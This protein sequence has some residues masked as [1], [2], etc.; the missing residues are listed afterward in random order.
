MTRL[1]ETLRG[2]TSRTRAAAD[3]SYA[4][5]PIT[6]ADIPGRW[7]SYVPAFR[8]YSEMGISQVAFQRYAVRRGD[9]GAGAEVHVQSMLSPFE[10][11]LLY[12]LAKDYYTGRGAIVDLGPYFGLSTRAL[13][14]GLRSNLRVP[15][16]EKRKRIHSFDLFLTAGYEWF[17]DPSTSLP[18]G[19]IFDF[20]LELNREYLDFISYNPGDLLQLDWTPQEIEILFIDIAKSWEL[21]GFVV[22]KMF[23]C[24]IPG[25]SIVIQQ[26]YVHFH[27]YWIHLTMQYLAEHFELVD[28]MYGATV[29]FLLKDAIPPARLATDLRSLSVEQKSDLLVAAREAAPDPIRESMKTAHAMMLADHGLFDAALALLHTVRAEKTTE[30]RTVDFAEVTQGNV[31]TVREVIRSRA[32]A[33][34]SS[35]VR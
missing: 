12:A 25:R 32:A 22:R 26:D 27:E 23:P 33:T 21:N 19:S 18:S 17:I 28:Y 24:L 3:R 16:S 29:A 6:V 7:R 35:E 8:S 31:D 2:W 15:S 13:A 1:L 30:D 11:T 14:H 20:V 9:A 34:P 5:G 10:L 4:G